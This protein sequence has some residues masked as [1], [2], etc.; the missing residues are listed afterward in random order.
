MNNSGPPNSVNYTQPGIPTNDLENSQR[1]INDLTYM[2]RNLTQS[3]R[4]VMIGYNTSINTYNQNIT[5]FLSTANDCRHDIRTIRAQALTEQQNLSPSTMPTTPIRPTRYGNTNVRRNANVETQNTYGTAQSSTFTSPESLF[6][7]IF[8]FP[9]SAGT[10]RYYNDVIVSP[11]Q[12]EIDNAVEVFNYNENR[13]QP[14]SRCPI[15]MEEFIAG[16]R[17]SRIR[18]CEHM[19]RED[20]INNWFRLNVRCPVCRYD[21]REYT[22]NATDVSNNATDVSNTI[23]EET[24]ADITTQI[25]TELTNLLTQAWQEQLQTSTSDPS[26]NPIFRFDIPIT[27][28]STY[29]NEYDEDDEVV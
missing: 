8:T 9:I 27:I 18:H 14:N 22:N 11:T 17:V 1:S 7:N 6:S 13:I 2:Y 20:A 21:I 4:D 24:E 26:Q 15:T 25:T 10:R 5:R 3:M 28:T 29:E 23:I 19:F 16:D 12:L